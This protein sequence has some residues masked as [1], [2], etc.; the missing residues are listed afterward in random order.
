MPHALLNETGTKKKMY[1]REAY[2]FAAEYK[3]NQIV[4]VCVCD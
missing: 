1:E 2:K 3:T 4:R